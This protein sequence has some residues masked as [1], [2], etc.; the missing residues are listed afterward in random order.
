MFS[1]DCPL[2]TPEVLEDEEEEEEETVREDDV[3][4]FR[5]SDGVKCTTS[6]PGLNPV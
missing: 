5:S 6:R 4:F 3:D 1:K 2:A